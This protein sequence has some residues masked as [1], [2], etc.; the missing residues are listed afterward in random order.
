MVVVFVV[1]VF[2]GVNFV[3]VDF[4]VVVFAVV[5]VNGAKPSTPFLLFLLPQACC[6]GFL[7]EEGARGCP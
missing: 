6:R 3:V 7:V 4:V 1:V 2:V 5:V